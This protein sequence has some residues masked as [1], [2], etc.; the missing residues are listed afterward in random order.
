MKNRLLTVGLVLILLCAILVHSEIDTGPSYSCVR[1]QDCSA[2]EAEYNV[3]TICS[4]VTHTCTLR[5]VC[6]IDSD[7]SFCDQFDDENYDYTCVCSEDNTCSQQDPVVQDDVV[8]EPIAQ[9]PNREELAAQ[10]QAQQ[11][12][13]KYE[14][15]QAQLATMGQDSAAI[16]TRLA[17]LEQMVASLQEG[18]SA[19]TPQVAVLRNDVDRIQMDLNQAQEGLSKKITGVSTGLAG[20][21]TN[22]G[23][24]N[25]DLDT[26][27]EKVAKE[28]E[29][30]STITTIFF[31]LLVISIGMA[32][33]YFATKDQKKTTSSADTAN[34]EI[35][36][37]ITGHVRQGRK[38]PQIKQTLLA[39]GWPEDQIEAAYK[40]TMKQNY[41]H[42]LEASGQTTSKKST[43][44]KEKAAP[45]KA[46]YIGMFAILIIVGVIFMF[47]GANAGRAIFF[48]VS[49][50]ESSEDGYKIQFLCLPP[51]MPSKVGCCL[52]ANNNQLCDFNEG[53]E[54]NRAASDAEKCTDN[55]QCIRGN[56]C[57][58]GGCMALSD[59]YEESNCDL[60]CN[61]KKVHIKTNDGHEYD[62]GIGGGDYT[63]AGGIEWE[64]LR[65]AD[66]CN[67]EPAKVPILITKKRG[68]EILEESVVA[69]GEGETSKTI[70]LPNSPGVR[71]E[72][73]VT[74]IA[75]Q[76]N[77]VS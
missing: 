4:P 60:K 27:E 75:Q 67:T 14:E 29:F 20:L 54:L 24:T 40:E 21:Q 30:T 25:K 55:T 56:Y 50:N 53:R 11:A 32:V 2:W 7:C 36:E 65:G 12:Q 34:S 33:Y 74:D 58:N 17:T 47:N 63:A 35:V 23:E 52:D 15:L 37:Y 10:L 13:E 9:E 5:Q 31:I 6:R 8:A 73:S 57:V 3:D 28:E 39:A 76:C 16:Q 26:V 48:N 44:R 72:I 68:R 59:L 46:A 61:L 51:H 22:L 18:Q 62:L 77:L 43:G 64:I 42:Y 70:T 49:A 66:Y 41:Q 45:A 69:L 1:D 71:F 19:F 38:Y